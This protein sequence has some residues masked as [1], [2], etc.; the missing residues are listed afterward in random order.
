MEKFLEKSRRKKAYRRGPNKAEDTLIRLAQENEVGVT[1]R[2]FP[3]FAVVRNRQIIG[4]IEVKRG[5]DNNMRP[6]QELFQVFCDDHKIPFAVW[7]PETPFPKFA[8]M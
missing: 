7:D 5:K 6:S 2:G 8:Q 1:R 4:F 3:D